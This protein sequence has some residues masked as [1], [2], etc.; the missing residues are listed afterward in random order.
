MTPRGTRSTTLPSAVRRLF[1]LPASRSRLMREADEEMQFHLNMWMAEFRARGMSSADAEAAAHRRFGDESEYREYSARRATWKT[2]WQTAAN[3]VEDVGQDVAYAWRGLRRSPGFTAAVVLVFALGLGANA[4]LFSLLDRIFLSAPAGVD[5]PQEIRRLYYIQPQSPFRAFE[6][7][8]G[9]LEPMDYPEYAA[10]RDA[11][12]S[13]VQFAAYW[14]PDSVDARI[15]NAVVAAMPSYVTQ[16]YFRALR[17]RPS[18]GRFFTA[19]EDRVDIVSPAAV[20]SDALWHR[21][22][23]G[24]SAVLGKQIRIADRTYSVVGVAPR[25]FTGID[26]DRA[27]LWLPLGALPPPP[28]WGSRPWYLGGFHVLRVIARVPSST[29]EQRMTAIATVAYRHEQQSTGFR[30]TT[31]TVITGPIIAALGPSDRKQ[32]VSISLRLAGVSLILLLIAVGNVAN[33]LLLRGM[34]R[35]REIAIRRALGVS[36]ARLCRLLITESL[37]LSTLGAAA[38]LILGA[39][40]STALR[41]LLLPETHW[42][43]DSHFAHVIAFTATVSI[44]VGTL[45]GM[46][47]AFHASGLDVTSALKAGVRSGLHRRVFTRSVLTMGQVALSVVL[48]VGAGLFVRSL[49]NVRAIDLGFDSD[50]LVTIHAGYRDLASSRAMG[51]AFESIAMEMSRVPGVRRIAMASGAPM[52]GSRSTRFFLPG[53]DSVPTIDG[54]PPLADLVS[55]E[56]FSTVGLRLVAGRRF[57]STDRAGMPP[58]A[59]VGR[60]M[61]SVVW[62]G[63]NPIG[64]CILTFTRTAPC[65]SVVGVVDDIHTDG[66]IEPRPFMHLYLP[67]A[68]NVQL[69]S[70]RFGARGIG[71]VILVRT[72]PGTEAAVK[73]FALRVARERLPGVDVL[74]ANDMAQVLAPKLRPWR[75]GATL[76]SILGVL[77]AVV[78]AVGMYSVIAYAVSQRAHEMSIRMALG[79]RAQDILTLVAREGLRVIIVSIAIGIG[80]AVPL[81]RLVASLLYGVSTRDPVVLTGAAV[82]LGLMGLAAIL[83]PAL[84]AARS[85]PAT[86]L[87]AE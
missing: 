16:S 83:T 23:A 15:D 18:L 19:D 46:A 74:R 72:R 59:V 31:S 65:T 12:K 26:L 42:S 9:V 25:G 7:A 52:Q 29:A 68:Q 1:R 28:F 35:R 50:G 43:N 55:P 87:R 75:L 32:E 11:A 21:A 2:R 54:I 73:K 57:E 27:D 24:E 36:T 82:L 44:V 49:R 60:T 53:R 22:F 34:R 76:F 78:A 39:W 41:A 71:R 69:D 37:L 17:V 61:A 38:A 79:A 81:G 20:I 47:P 48:L 45:A 77:A 70:L 86:A 58:V 84:R 85:D 6:P 64:K 56:Y 30:D 33:L 63:E 10:I 5:A 66:V 40:A 51:P 13:K 4:A 3:W 67:F 62:P 80:A 14:Q 8:N